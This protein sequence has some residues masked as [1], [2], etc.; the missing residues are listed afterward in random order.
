MPRKLKK[1]GI[2]PEGFTFTKSEYTRLRE[3]YLRSE[4]KVVETMLH[5]II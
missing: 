5:H 1:K 4:Y 2:P 3:H